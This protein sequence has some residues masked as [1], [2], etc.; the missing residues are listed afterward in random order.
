MIHRFLLSLVIAG[1]VPSAAR[2]QTP[3]PPV[4]RATPYTQTVS[5]NPL[6]LPFGIYSA[7]YEVAV[8]GGGGLAVGVGGT[9]ASD[10][11][12]DDEGDGGDGSRDV[13]FE[14]K[15]LYYPSE[16]ALRGFSTGLTLGYHNARN[17]GGDLFSPGGEVRSEG[18]PTIG[19]LLDYNWLLG[20]RR[21]FLVGTGIGARRVMK[22]VDAGSPLEQVY[23]DGRLQIG[24][25][26]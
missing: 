9:Y 22:Q 8:P 1:A 16:V 13:W 3:P 5:I 15:V 10:F 20:P 12:E 18:A 21:R 2:A 7:E 23:P 17:D 25:A 4:V 26:F 19:V 11:F 14:G 24:L 6:G